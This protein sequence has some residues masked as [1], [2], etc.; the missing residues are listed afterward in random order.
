ME[1]AYL[2]ALKFKRYWYFFTKLFN[3]PF[4]NLGYESNHSNGDITSQEV[5]CVVCLSQVE[6]GEEVKELTCNHIFHRV[7]LERWVGFGHVT[8][9]LCR[10]LLKSS[11]I[12]LGK[13]TL[14]FKFDDLCS[15]DKRDSWWLR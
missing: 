5:E 4:E 3:L 14:V 8:C 7:C 2:F 13:C 6:E 12:E 15:R 9:P 1:Y 11:A 10:G